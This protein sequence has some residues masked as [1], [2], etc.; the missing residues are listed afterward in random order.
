MDLLMPDQ[1]SELLQFVPQIKTT[2]KHWQYVKVRVMSDAGQ[3]I[4]I[5]QIA[6]GICD[7]YKFKRG[8]AYICN[9]HEILVLVRLGKD[10]DHHAVTDRIKRS[11]PQY[12]FEVFVDNIS[13]M[14]LLKLEFIIQ[15]INDPGNMSKDAFSRLRKSRNHNCIIVADDDM[16]IRTLIESALKGRGEIHSIVDGNTVLEE[17]HR[18]APDIILLDIHMPGKSGPELVKEILEIDPE[19]YI[20]M[21]SADSSRLNVMLTQKEGASGFLT[22]PFDKSKLMEYVENCPTLR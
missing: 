5:Q 15:G 12:S 11:F 14:G 21:L 19:A 2:I 16:Y 17:Y 10:M 3:Q 20:V 18:L 4:N 1:C 6:A 22:K 13:K 7:I 9:D 8:K